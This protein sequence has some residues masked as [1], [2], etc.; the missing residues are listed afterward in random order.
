MAYSGIM[1]ELKSELQNLSPIHHQVKRKAMN[2]PPVPPSNRGKGKAKHSKGDG[3]NTETSISWQADLQHTSKLVDFLISNMA[4]CHI[5]FSG[6]GKKPTNPNIEGPPSGKDKNAIHAVIAEVIFSDDKVYAG[7]YAANQT[8]FHDSVANHIAVL[9]NKFSKVNKEF[10]WYDNLYKIWGSNPS[11][12]AK[13]TS[14]KPGADHA[15]L[16]IPPTI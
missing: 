11:F 6:E 2:P 1:L 14:S 5:L 16:F 9:W 15:A 4:N 7:Q 3:D 13:M 10:P 12:A 8:R